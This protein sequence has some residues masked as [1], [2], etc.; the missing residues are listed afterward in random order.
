MRTPA[1]FRFVEDAVDAGQFAAFVAESLAEM[2]DTLF[3]KSAWQ[4]QII[5]VALLVTVAERKKSVMH[6]QRITVP[7]NLQTAGFP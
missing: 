4:I 7:K 1:R 3:A 6:K 5:L 2:T